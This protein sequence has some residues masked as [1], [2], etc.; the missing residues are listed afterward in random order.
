MLS[1]GGVVRLSGFADHVPAI[2]EGWLLGQAG[3]GAVAD[4][5]LRRVNPSGRLAETIP[6]RLEDSPAFLDFPGEHG[7]VRYGE[8]LFVGYRWYDARDIRGLLSRSVTASRTRPSSTRTC[9]WPSDA[10]GLVA[11]LTVANTG[12]RDGAEIVQLYA[13]LRGLG[14][15]CARRASS[16]ASPRCTCRPASRRR[17][18][19]RVARDDLA[20]WETRLDRWVVEGGE[21]RI[22][23]GASSR[24]LRLAATVDGRRRRRSTCR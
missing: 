18:R 22:E 19:S 24:D 2:L 1:N 3:G 23:V 9:R 20:Y 12:D 6:L 4:V 16:R 8:G 10:D 14:R 7:H 21:Y 15:S 5:R 11:R 13:A 17:S